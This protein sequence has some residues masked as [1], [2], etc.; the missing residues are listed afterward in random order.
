MENISKEE[1]IRKIYYNPSSPGS[2]GGAE[3]LVKEAKKINPLIDQKFVKDWLSGEL[4]Y[5]LHKQ[6]KHHFKRNPIV[7]EAPK[8][9]MQAD[10]VDMQAFSTSNNG[11][12]FILTAID[13]FSKKAYAIPI[14]NK[15]QK[16]VADAMEKI[17]TEH[18]PIK[19]QTDEGKE[20]KNSTFENLM[21]KY[22]IIHF[23]TKNRD[24]KCAIV[25]R[26]NKTLKNKMFRYFTLKGNR[27]Y[28]D[29]IDKILESY[30]NSYHR[31]IK[32]TPNQVTIGNSNIVFSNLYGFADKRELLKKLKKPK[33]DGTV[34]QKYPQKLLD[35]GYYPLWTDRLYEVY[36]SIPGKL[37]PYYVLRDEQGNVEKKK[38]YPEEIQKV[39]RNL[40]RVE[41][42]LKERK[43]KGKKQFF[44]KWLN[45]PDSFNSWI[46]AENL[47]NING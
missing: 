45:Y 23:F 41:K 22:E 14:K 33:I 13:V 12:K 32:M 11:F 8:E 47:T 25:E 6:A 26:F 37:K 36:K 15:S 31:S 24:I 2:F 10:L 20:F 16:S 4:V 39:K 38:F 34:R 44:V 7:A 18:E 17:I 43:Y 27:K 28:I 46:D 35:R 5:T 9:N 42:V 30:N 40:E 21:K 1:V 3:A 29:V 19:L